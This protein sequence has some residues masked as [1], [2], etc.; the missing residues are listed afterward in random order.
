[1]PIAPTLSTVITKDA[2]KPGNVA[3]ARSSILSTHYDNDNSLGTNDKN[4]VSIHLNGI[5]AEKIRRKKSLSQISFFY[6]LSIY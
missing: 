2:E 4:G 5:I 1:M 6:V 3:Q